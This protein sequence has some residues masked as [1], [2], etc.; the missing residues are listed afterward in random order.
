MRENY[1]DPARSVIAKIGI[2]K[3]A[4]LTGKHRSRIYRWMYPKERGG[5]GG[6]IP[7]DVVV[8]LRAYVED[9]GIDLTADDFMPKP[10]NCPPPADKRWK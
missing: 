8:V 6:L 5:T 4:R 2:E 10:G 3:V 9:A 7:Y 1:L